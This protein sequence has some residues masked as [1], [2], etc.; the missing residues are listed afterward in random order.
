MPPITR[1]SGMRCR[2]MVSQAGMK[3]QVG[4]RLLGKRVPVQAEEMPQVYEEAVHRPANRSRSSRTPPPPP[5]SPPPPMNQRRQRQE[6]QAGLSIPQ[7]YYQPLWCI[8]W[9]FICWKL[10]SASCDRSCCDVCF[11]VVN[12]NNNSTTNSTSA[13]TS[14]CE[15]I[16]L[17]G[18]C[19]SPDQEI[20]VSLP[21]ITLY[22]LTGT[23]HSRHIHITQ[24]RTRTIQPLPPRLLPPPLPLPRHPRN[25][26]QHITESLLFLDIGI[27]STHA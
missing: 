21:F 20:K 8:F 4:P 26:A 15:I 2:A 13:S 1:S 22:K 16:I 7:Q 10:A 12:S 14:D 24:A 27:C 19:S 6:D 3:Q 9:T 23:V 18:R 11:S 5:H 17:P 25:H